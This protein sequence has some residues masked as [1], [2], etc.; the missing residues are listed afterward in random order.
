MKYGIVVRAYAGPRS[1]GSVGDVKRITEED[2]GA[3]E[4]GAIREIR[5]IRNKKVSTR[6]RFEQ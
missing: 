5:P 2:H 3:L 1:R 6:H 4:S